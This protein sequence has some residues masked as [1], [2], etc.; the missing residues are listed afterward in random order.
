M[1]RASVPLLA[2]LASIA[3]WSP[4]AEAHKP[5][6]SYLSVRLEGTRVSGQWDIA[7]RDLDYAI[8][9]DGDDD[10]VLTWGEVRAQTQRIAGYAFAH[11]ALRL[12]TPTCTP[13][14]DE[15]LIDRHTDGAYAV[16]RF[17][18]TGCEAAAADAALTVAY[19]LFFDVDPQHRGLVHVDYARPTEL[20]ATTGYDA[21]R[22]ALD[23][24]F[25]GHSDVVIL[26]PDR[27]AA[28]FARR[29]PSRL[30]T[31]ATFVENGIWH[32]WTGFDHLLFLVSLL[33]PAVARRTDRRWHVVPCFRDAL[34]DTV[35]VVTAFTVA[36]SITLSAAAL[37]IVDLPSRL[38]ESA[39]A[40]S[41]AVAAASNL[42]P[43]LDA[44]R[45][46][47]I[48]FLFG[49]VHG[50]GFASVLT[51]LGLGRGALALA[52]VGLNAGVEIGQLA[53]VAALLPIA[54]AL[55]RTAGF[56]WGVM[57][58]GSVAIVVVALGWLGERALN[59]R[60]FS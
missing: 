17:G 10:G 9:L 13:T 6:D 36:H 31:V 55:R 57:T 24:M 18:A 58:A 22:G 46:W 25:S 32:I 43:L 50:F 16:L 45:T 15:L 38:V 51:E 21:A 59:V 5:S 52:L 3:A 39:I 41:V 47:Q 35:R 28:T 27:R 12:G 54:F 11:L 60:I 19:D 56:R 48:A 42:V 40:L 1:S 23:A 4:P 29:A 49:L 44:R 8:A 33:L 37:G 7:L 34:R 26:A 53:I 20:R 2:L 30:T 14:L